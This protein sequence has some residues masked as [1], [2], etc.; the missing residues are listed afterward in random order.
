[1]NIWWASLTAGLGCLYAEL[2][3][4]VV[5]RWVDERDVCLPWRPAVVQ[6]KSEGHGGRRG[7]LAVPV[8]RPVVVDRG[9]DRA[10][11]VHG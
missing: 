9:A 8:G 6:V 11:R 7:L 10:G 2:L 5:A 1:M 4:Q 3:H